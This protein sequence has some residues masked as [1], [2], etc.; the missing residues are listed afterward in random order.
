MQPP[1]RRFA[2]SPLEGGT[3]LAARRSRFRGVCWS[4]FAPLFLVLCASA[5]LA[6]SPASTSSSVSGFRPRFNEAYEARVTRVPDGDTLWVKPLAGGTYRKLR[7]DGVDAPEICQDGGVAARE[8]LTARLLEQTVTVTERRRDDYGRALVRL[9]HRGDDVAGWLV[10]EGW[11]WSYRWRH[12]D[13]P[14][15]IEE[16]LARKDRKGIFASAGAENPRDFRKRHGPCPMP[17][18]SSAKD[19]PSR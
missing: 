7:L 9:K 5:S 16:V 1:L 13:G 11:A 3:T 4:L 8:A 14:F 18:R 12:S 19:Q 15:A 6:E 2:A 17:P 10:R